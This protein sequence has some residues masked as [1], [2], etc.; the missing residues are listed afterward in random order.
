MRP[1]QLRFA[2]LRDILLR[3]AA[4]VALGVEADINGRAGPAGSV[5][6]DPFRTSAGG[7]LREN[8]LRSWLRASGLIIN[9][10]A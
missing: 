1:K 6:N 7:R 9:E 2:A 4:V 5:A 3:R 8:Y 10:A